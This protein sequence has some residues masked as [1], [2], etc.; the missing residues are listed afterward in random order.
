M[1]SADELYRRSA[2]MAAF[3]ARGNRPRKEL[4]RAMYR[5]HK[6]WWWRRHTAVLGRADFTFRRARVLVFL[7]G[8]LWL[9]CPRCYRVPRGNRA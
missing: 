7:D 4:F 3:D 9:G 1:L 6:V 8:R 2:V 5:R